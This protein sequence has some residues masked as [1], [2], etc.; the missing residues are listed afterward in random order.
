[1]VVGRDLIVY[2]VY[3]SC[4]LKRGA[5][6]TIQF[7]SPVCYQCQNR[8]L[9]YIGISIGPKHEV[10]IVLIAIFTSW[11]FGMLQFIQLKL[12]QSHGHWHNKAMGPLQCNYYLFLCE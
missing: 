10:S 9:L 11:S 6:A 12:R 1:M 4:I 5:R 3:L 8:L 2:P 7:Y